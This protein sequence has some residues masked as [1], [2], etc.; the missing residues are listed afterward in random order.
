MKQLVFVFTLVSLWLSPQ[1]AAEPCVFEAQLVLPAA[2]EGR[3]AE[4]SQVLLQAQRRLLSFARRQDCDHLMLQP[5]MAR[6]QIFDNKAAFDAHLRR[7]FQASDQKIPASF[8]A[9]F[10]GG[11][12][13]D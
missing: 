4:F 11:D 12:F 9:G 7:I 6:A 3:R 8:V 13:L 1:L 2:L 5:L 10:V